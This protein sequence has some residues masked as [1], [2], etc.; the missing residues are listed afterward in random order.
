MPYDTLIAIA[1]VLLT[2]GTSWYDIVTDILS[3]LDFLN[4]PA[5]SITPKNCTFPNV[6]YTE[7]SATDFFSDASKNCTVGTEV[8]EQHLVWGFLSLSIIFLPGINFTH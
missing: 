6:N 4:W 3:G 2:I 8:S 7:V 1:K 5:K